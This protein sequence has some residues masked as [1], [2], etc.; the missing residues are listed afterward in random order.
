MPGLRGR[1]VT[2]TSSKDFRD[3]LCRLYGL[4]LESGW[5][6]FH[7]ADAAKVGRLEL[8]AW[9]KGTRCP[10]TSYERDVVLTDI[11]NQLELKPI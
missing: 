3:E 4:A 7:M 2:A 8:V 10:A 1:A 6:S 9:M 5:M 11:V